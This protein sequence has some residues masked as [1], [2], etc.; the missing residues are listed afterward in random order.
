MSEAFTQYY[1]SR[2]IFKNAYINGLNEVI[3]S[4]SWDF[5]FILAIYTAIVPKCITW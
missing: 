5:S 4:F 2:C 3:L 1:K